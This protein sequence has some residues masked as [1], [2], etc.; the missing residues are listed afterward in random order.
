MVL[1]DPA[2]PGSAE[3]DDALLAHLSRR[4]RHVQS[5][6][7]I[8]RRR[9]NQ[10]RSFAR[11]II[12]SNFVTE[13]QNS[14]QVASIRQSADCDSRSAGD[15]RGGAHQRPGIR[16]D[17]R[18]A[19]RGTFEGPRCGRHGPANASP[20][21]GRDAVLKE[22]DQAI[23]GRLHADPH[24]GNFFI[25]PGGRIAFVDFGMMGRVSR[26]QATADHEAPAGA[27]GERAPRPCA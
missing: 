14:E 10:Y 16:A 5:W 22:D 12:A 25:L 3:T 18:P 7:P 24:P 1:G 8:T 23:D 9:S 19:G 15:G 11:A 20:R 26:A 2:P 17:V 21:R 27:D 6:P 4:Q 13:A